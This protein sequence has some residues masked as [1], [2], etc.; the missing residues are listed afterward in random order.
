MNE[1]IKIFIS[2]G[3]TDNNQVIPDLIKLDFDKILKKSGDTN[4]KLTFDREFL[5]GGDKWDDRIKEELRSSNVIFFL[6]NDKFLKSEYIKNIEFAESIRRTD[7]KIFHAKLFKCDNYE[8]LSGIQSINL[9]NLPYL[10]MTEEEYENNDKNRFEIKQIAYQLFVEIKSNFGNNTSAKTDKYVKPSAELLKLIIN[11]NEEIGAFKSLVRRANSPNCNMFVYGAT[12]LDVPKYFNYRTDETVENIPAYLSVNNPCYMDLR[13]FKNASFD[14]DL[15][16]N[17]I[18]EVRRIFSPKTDTETTFA[19]INEGVSLLYDG[20]ADFS[21]KRLIIPFSFGELD[22]NDEIYIKCFLKL[23]SFFDF[24]KPDNSKTYL[25]F[26]I[27][28]QDYNVKDSKLF[29]ALKKHYGIKTFSILNE[30]QL[31]DLEKWSEMV[32]EDKQS[33]IMKK[34]ENELMADDKRFPTRMEYLR[35]PIENALNEFYN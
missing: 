33:D 26:L 27:Q 16:A 1:T 20:L 6:L 14:L 25:Y 19:T 31:S 12:R 23:L 5:N 18:S 30:I 11:R 17:F 13:M 7:V 2:Y 3:V 22:A 9:S 8:G 28:I 24:V 34:I 10:D 35:K 29:K 21:I 4:I 32:N 15:L